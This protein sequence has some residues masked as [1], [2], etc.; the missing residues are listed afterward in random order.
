M[1]LMD[2]LLADA[3][4]AGMARQMAREAQRPPPDNFFILPPEPEAW[5]KLRAACKEEH[6]VVCIEIT[7]DSH[8]PSKRIQPLIVDLARE[9]SQIPFFRVK[10]G[11]GSSSHDQ[12]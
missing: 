8:P 5:R 1:D 7:D 2:L 10:I 3:L 6:M 12:V 4:S 11:T 9:V